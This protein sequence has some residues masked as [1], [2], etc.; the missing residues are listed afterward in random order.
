VEQEPPKPCS[1]PV[2]SEGGEAAHLPQCEQVALQTLFENDSALFLAFRAACI[3]QFA[4]DFQLAAGLLA[5][6]QDRAALCRLA[7]SLKGVLNTLGHTEIS[8]MAHALQLEAERAN[9]PELQ[10]LWSALR[11]R[12]VAAFGLDPLA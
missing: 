12:M 3:E 4:H 5:A 1:L 9:W 10:R 7:H 11:A 8:P 6:Q 2:L